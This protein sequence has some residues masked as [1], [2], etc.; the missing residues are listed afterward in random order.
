[1][2]DRVRVDQ[3]AAAVFEGKR[4]EIEFYYADSYRIM[5]EANRKLKDKK[6]R[7]GRSA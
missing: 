5:L 2:S 7:I 3:L 6:K 1:M 4:I